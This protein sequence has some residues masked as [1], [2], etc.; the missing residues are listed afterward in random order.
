MFEIPNG[1]AA[2]RRRCATVAYLICTVAFVASIR[3]S[4][5]NA[6]DA[7]QQLE[8]C[9]PPDQPRPAAGGTTIYPCT[10]RTAATNYT[11]L[12][13]CQARTLNDTPFT[14]QHALPPFTATLDL[15]SNLLTA[16]PVLV[17]NRLTKL[18]L[19]HNRITLLY[20]RNFEQCGAQ[21]RELSLAW[22]QIERISSNAFHG[23]AALQRLDLTKNHLARLPGNVF[24][25]L[26][27]LRWLDVS[28]N[29]QLNA[30]FDAAGAD[31][32]L[33]LGVST[34]LHT[35]QADECSLHGGVRLAGG[36]GLRELSL[37]YNR[38]ERIPDVPRGLRLLDV[39]GNP[40][41]RL[42]AKSLPL[43]G[44]LEEL[45]LQDMPNLTSVEEWSLEAVVPQLR[46]LTLAG[47]WRLNRFDALAFGWWPAQANGSR[48]SVGNLTTL[49]LSG[50]ALTMVNGTVPEARLTHMIAGLRTLNVMGAP[51][52]CD[53]AMRWLLEAKLEQL[54]GVCARPAELHDRRLAEL[55]VEALGCRWWPTWVYQVL[56]GLAILGMLVV[57]VT[58]TWCLVTHIRPRSRRERLQKV[59]DASPYARVT[60]EPTRGEL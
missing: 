45:L 32:Y 46:V 30:T 5:V 13:D 42:T 36:V 12:I 40:V 60:I 14:Y 9:A 27:A 44:D 58:A 4:T 50:T 35:L 59:G 56:N 51:I 15:S 16:V 37:K 43:L 18:D 47:S 57:C 33:T 38:M 28:R 21:L 10:C 24:S 22:N 19:G 26:P 7:D 2:A 6:S 54:L 29:R 52:R 25:P 49:N 34:L 20:D 41:Q 23:L 31:L 11:I 48:S 53:C 3:V 39:S 1:A 55:P 17:A 8:L